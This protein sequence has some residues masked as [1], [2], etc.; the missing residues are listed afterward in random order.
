MKTEGNRFS[1]PSVNKCEE[2]KIVTE[3]S[4]KNLEKSKDEIKV[5]KKIE[6][7]LT[8]KKS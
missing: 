4:R 2:V 1:N 5:K 8:G 3:S 6:N 7:L